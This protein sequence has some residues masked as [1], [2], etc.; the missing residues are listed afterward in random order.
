MTTKICDYVHVANRA[1]ELG[2]VT[3]TGFAVLPENFESA[4]GRSSLLFGSQAATMLKLLK[5]DGLP[6]TNLLPAGE[7][8]PAIHNKHFEWAPAIFVSA[9]LLSENPSAVAVA[10]G[11]ISNYATE[12]FKGMPSRNVKLTIVVEIKKDRSCK[13]IN[14]EG[15]ASGLAHIANIVRQ[16]SDE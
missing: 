5:K 16:I 9:A 13:K 2:C 6:V 14:Y 12:F 15:D 4:A 10:L 3:P 1:K 7:R 8:A 11:I